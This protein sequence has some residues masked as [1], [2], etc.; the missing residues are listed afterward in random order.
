VNHS[1]VDKV[2]EVVVTLSVWDDVLT[3]GSNR[4]SSRKFL[5]LGSWS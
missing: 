3:N 2:A 5:L 4:R 1:T